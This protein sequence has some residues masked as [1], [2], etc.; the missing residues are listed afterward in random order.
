[1]YAETS[2][3]AE[4]AAGWH[5]SFPLSESGTCRSVS[6]QIPQTTSELTR[7]MKRFRTPPTH[8]DIDISVQWTDRL[9]RTGGRKLFDSRSIWVLHEEDD[10]FVFDFSTPVLGDRP[11]KRL[12]VDRGFS[13]A[14]LWLNRECLPGRG[15]SI[16]LSI[17]WTNCWLPTGYQLGLRESRFTAV[18]WLIAERAVISFWAT[19][20]PE[21]ARRQAFGDPFE[22]RM[23]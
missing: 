3:V 15:E 14:R 19:R 8:C 13:A 2:G 9:R 10:D 23:F 1:M 17:P 6:G 7:E 16:R 4:R 12:S 11:Y 21:R 5:V 22:R 20:V 18:A